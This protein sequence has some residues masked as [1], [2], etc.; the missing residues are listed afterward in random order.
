MSKDGE[1]S[2]QDPAS[3][4]A[5]MRAHLGRAALIGLCFGVAAIGLWEN[6]VR[7]S[8]PAALSNQADTPPR[9]VG[10]SG[11][12]GLQGPTG[13][14]GVERKTDCLSFTETPS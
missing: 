12:L 8:D 10:E 9:T 14:H 7:F 11:P 2:P 6:A 3:P 1:T 13:A 5:R 4:R